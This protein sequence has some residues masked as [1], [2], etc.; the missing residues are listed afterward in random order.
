LQFS[1]N[2]AS[3]RSHPNMTR[4]LASVRD[5]AEA[6]A[7]LASGADIIDLKDPARG[8]LGALASGTIAQ[9]VAA[10][11]GRAEMS[12]TVGDLPMVPAIVRN[13][14]LATAATGVDYVKL[15]LFPGGDA[16]GCLNLLANP[17]ADETRAVRLILVVFA[18]APPSFDAIGAASRFRASGIRL[19]TMRK[20]GRSL[21]DHVPLDRLADFVAAGRAEGLLVGLAGSLKAA[22]VPALLPLKPDLL[23][24]RGALCRNGARGASL[25]AT[26]CA[27]I[28]A[29]IP[30]APRQAL[31]STMPELSPSL[32]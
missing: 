13:A 20:D 27:A 22:Q 5:P 11:S 6:D 19:D 14:V 9:C 10:I 16:Q 26:A 15:G 23:G 28:R 18:D 24:F 8:A 31:L 21:L 12:A 30:A 29:L 4:F 25:D 3:L 7:A 17:L 1:P 2:D 32:C